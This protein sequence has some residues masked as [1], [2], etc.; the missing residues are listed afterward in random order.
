MPSE[1]G[2]KWVDMLTKAFQRAVILP[3]GLRCHYIYLLA[4]GEYE[5]SYQALQVH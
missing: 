3:D 2:R 5:Y 1:F 4:P